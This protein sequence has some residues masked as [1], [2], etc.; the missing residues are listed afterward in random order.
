L[1]FYGTSNGSLRIGFAANGCPKKNQYAIAHKL[2][3]GAIVPS[4]YV[5]HAAQIIIEYLN[6]L[7]WL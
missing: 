6:D 4:D 1:H 3:N 2:I 5:G 7:F